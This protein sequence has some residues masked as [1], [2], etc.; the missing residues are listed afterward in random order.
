MPDKYFPNQF[1]FPDGKPDDR[2]YEWRMMNWVTKLDCYDL[3]INLD[4]LPEGFEVTFNTAG[5]PSYAICDA[6]REIYPEVNI[7]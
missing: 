2:C 7:S 4:N 5:S 3:N 1:Y 6:I